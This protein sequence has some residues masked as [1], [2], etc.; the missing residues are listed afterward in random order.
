MHNSFLAISLVPIL[1]LYDQLLHPSA[2]VVFLQDL[3][4]REASL[5]SRAYPFE[6]VLSASDLRRRLSRITPTSSISVIPQ[7]YLTSCYFVYDNAL[8]ACVNK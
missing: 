4:G 1:F 8:E 6:A 5:K 3:V 7:L 2:F